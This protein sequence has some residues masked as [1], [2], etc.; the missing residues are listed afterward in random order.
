MTDQP[1][2]PADDKDIEVW[3]HSSELT[4]AEMNEMVAPALIARV[5]A[6]AVELERLRA[7]L[8]KA[9]DEQRIEWL[10]AF[11]ADVELIKRRNEL[12]QLRSENAT[13]RG[14]AIAKFSDGTIEREW[15]SR[16]KFAELEAERAR[17][18]AAIIECRANSEIVDSGYCPTCDEV[19]SQNPCVHI[20]VWKI[21]D[22]ALSPAS[23]AA[24]ELY[25]ALEAEHE[26]VK[27]WAKTPKKYYMGADM[28]ADEQ[29][30][31][32]SYRAVEAA[33][34]ADNSGESKI[35]A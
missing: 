24:G 3:E 28:P 35:G 34:K 17:L 4:L 29:G 18:A 11:D 12:E 26:A 13:L 30:L 22:D 16:E 19:N 32:D 8:A 25:R 14:A 20:A 31:V 6:A 27:A 33:R 23:R 10:R 5:R 9:K 15:V 21:V 1:V 2:T 7:E